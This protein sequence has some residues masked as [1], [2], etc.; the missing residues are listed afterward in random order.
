MKNKRIDKYWK[1]AK[2]M[3]R[4]ETAS[5]ILVLAFL[6]AALSHIFVS[7]QLQQGSIHEG[8]I[9]LK[10]VYAPYDFGYSWQVDEENTL[11]AKESALK[12]VP[13]ALQ[14][15]LTFEEEEK[16]ALERFLDV[17]EEE[18]ERDAPVKEKISV[19]KKEG[20]GGK[21]S[22]KNLK[23]LLEYPDPAGLREKALTALENIF[24]TGYI[25]SSSLNFLTE[26][27]LAKWLFSMKRQALK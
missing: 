14:R 25:S 24:L 15:D 9:A 20:P 23:F 1:F 13:Y 7:P 22:E 3:V 4:K 2:S 6:A 8:D 12:K 11:K 10:D 19:L 26:K 17:L 27:A 5:I 18:K 21:L 16:S